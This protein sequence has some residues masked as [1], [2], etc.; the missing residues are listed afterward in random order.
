VFGADASGRTH[1]VWGVQ[2]RMLGALAFHSRDPVS[3]CVV[4]WRA[5]LRVGEHAG[6][7][8]DPCS[9]RAYGVRGE[10][11]DPTA[12][13]PLDRF[14]LDDDGI[15]VRVFVERLHPLPSAPTRTPAPR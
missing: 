2:D 14:E 6:V 1:G 15:A 4:A 5:E 7:F 3:V 8:R 9:E 10:R 13:R 11:L 12:P